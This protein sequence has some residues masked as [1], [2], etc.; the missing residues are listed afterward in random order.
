MA[1]NYDGA[2]TGHVATAYNSDV[3][4]AIA[5]DKSRQDRQILR[6]YHMGLSRMNAL[7]N[8]FPRFSRSE[9]P[10]LARAPKGPN[11]YTAPML[12]F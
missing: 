10:L 5:K 7:L 9:R 8:G 2:V 6:F 11:P 4:P 3:L 12:T 1:R